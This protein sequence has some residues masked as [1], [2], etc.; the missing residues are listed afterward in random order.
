MAL[1]RRSLGTR[2]LP[3]QRLDWKRARHRLEPEFLPPEWGALLAY[4]AQRVQ[5]CAPPVSGGF[6]VERRPTNSLPRVLSP[7]RSKLPVRVA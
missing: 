4:P 3:L 1:G 6:L 5:D 7:C 2:L